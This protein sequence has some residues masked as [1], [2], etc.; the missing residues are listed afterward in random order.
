[1]A[2]KTTMDAY[3]KTGFAESSGVADLQQ[4][5]SNLTLDEDALRQQA[6]ERYTPTYEQEKASLNNQFTALIK[7][8]TDD[9][10]LLNKQYQQS[11]NTMMDKLAKRG[12]HVGSMPDTTSAALNQFRNEVM[13]ERQRVYNQ[14]QQGI[15]NVQQTLEGNY[16]LNI[17]ARMNDI[18]QGNLASLTSLL[19]TIS[20]LQT[21]SYNDYIN[22]LLA[23]KHS[24]GGGG[25][26]RY[27]RRS[28]GGTAAA[29]AASKS[30]VSSSYYKGSAK[31][32]KV[33]SRKAV[34]VR[35]TAK[36]NTLRIKYDAYD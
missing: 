33:P 8:Q 9:S 2:D 26:R 20:K 7:S 16:E 28:G 31:Q 4:Q 29:P 34:S 19:E 24:G 13:S 5:V 1:M 35:G 36:G 27:G 17:Q 30:S 25:G 10:D 11:V 21:S 32:T 23:K 12:L 22:Y 6:V 18:R 15:Q 3:S 14:Q